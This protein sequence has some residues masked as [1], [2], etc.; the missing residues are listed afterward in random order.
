[1]EKKVD[2]IKF[3]DVGPLAEIVYLLLPLGE[4]KWVLA[5]WLVGWNMD[6]KM[7]YGEQI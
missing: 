3:I 2:Q 7:A 1:M 6:Q 5:V 4:L